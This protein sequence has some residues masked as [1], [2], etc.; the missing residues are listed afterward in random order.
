MEKV[1][2]K[3]YPPRWPAQIDATRLRTLKELLE[4]TC[5]QHADRVRVDAPEQQAPQR[6]QAV[7]R[8]EHERIGLAQA[9]GFD[10][11]GAVHRKSSKWGFR[12]RKIAQPTTRTSTAPSKAI[13]S[14]ASAGAGVCSS[15]PRKNSG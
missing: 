1:W 4:T 14:P 6:T 9:A 15:T 11:R 7:A 8:A 12:R 13:V 2:L 10:Q 3:S 5:A